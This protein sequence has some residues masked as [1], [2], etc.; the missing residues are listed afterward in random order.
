MMPMVLAWD[1]GDR[2][3]LHHAQRHA[4][5]LIA[6]IRKLQTSRVPGV[7]MSEWKALSITSPAN[8]VGSLNS[9]AG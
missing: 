5:D 2:P 4:A 1:K 7:V 3:V 9:T 8:P 6:R